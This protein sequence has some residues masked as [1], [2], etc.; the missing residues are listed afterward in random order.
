MYM[1]D[2]TMKLL[3]PLTTWHDFDLCCLALLNEAAH[4]GL[5]KDELICIILISSL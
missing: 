4:R 2:D 5:R 3:V 1:V